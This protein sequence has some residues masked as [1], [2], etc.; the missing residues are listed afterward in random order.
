MKNIIIILILLTG[1]TFAQTDFEEWQPKESSYANKIESNNAEIQKSKL[2]FA[3]DIYKFFV[4][5]LDGDNCPFHPTCSQ[6]LVEAVNET[7]FFQG[8][9]MFADRFTR[10]AN[11]FKTNYTLHK[12][13]K[14]FD[15]VEN[16]LLKQNSINSN[17]LKIN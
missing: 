17:S 12:S 14:F 11:L 13:G 10:D 6:F 2:S 5:D 4:S 16:Y 3:K 8:I 9:L 15:P 7:N 1:I